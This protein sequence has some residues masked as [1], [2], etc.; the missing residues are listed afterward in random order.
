MPRPGDPERGGPRDLVQARAESAVHRWI[1]RRAR[2]ETE[3]NESEIIRRCLWFALP[4]MPHGW[5]PE[6]Q[7]NV[8]PQTE[9]QS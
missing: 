7:Q 9:E 3:G 6:E 2:S 5:V 1:A 8:P 4:R